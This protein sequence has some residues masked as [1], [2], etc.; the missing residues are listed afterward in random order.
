MMIAGV[1]PATVMAVRPMAMEAQAT[2]TAVRVTV[3]EDRVTV[4]APPVMAMADRAM[5][6]ALQLMAMEDQIMVAALRVMGLEAPIMVTTLQG[7]LGPLRHRSRARAFEL[8]FP[9]PAPGRQHVNVGG[10]GNTLRPSDRKLEFGHLT[11]FS[12]KFQ[13]IDPALVWGYF[14]TGLAPIV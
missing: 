12:S 7:K 6:T 5:V 13:E 11:R 9:T 1:A 10:R 8:L 2:V 3:M 4:T 14:F